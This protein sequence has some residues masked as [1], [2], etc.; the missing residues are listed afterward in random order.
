ME[1]AERKRKVGGKG[2]KKKEKEEGGRDIGYKG[3]SEWQEV[4]GKR[5]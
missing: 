2:K 3:R 4:R 1:R 5:N